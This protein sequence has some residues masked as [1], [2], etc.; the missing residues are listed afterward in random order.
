MELWRSRNV[1][2]FLH[3]SEEEQGLFF[4]QLMVTRQ[5]CIYREHLGMMV[6]LL[7]QISWQT[8]F[9]QGTAQRSDHHN[10]HQLSQKHDRFVTLLECEK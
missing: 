1:C 10:C 5:A 2:P 7:G 3:G 8:Y 6:F 4:L 9:M